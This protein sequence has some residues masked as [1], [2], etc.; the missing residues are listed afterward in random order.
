MR[1]K[2][3]FLRS[4]YFN[5][6]DKFPNIYHRGVRCKLHLNYSEYALLKGDCIS[7]QNKINDELE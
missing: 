6:A 7:I 5:I 1:N 4:I 2:R 3:I